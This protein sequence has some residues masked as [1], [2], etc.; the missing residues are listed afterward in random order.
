M[1]G[2]RDS[3]FVASVP[4]VTSFASCSFVPSVREDSLSSWALLSSVT[5]AFLAKQRVPGWHNH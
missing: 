4:D 1:T 5:V 2:V 3:S